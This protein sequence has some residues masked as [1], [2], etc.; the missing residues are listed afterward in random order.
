M[1]VFAAH[2]D[3]I[4]HT[5]QGVAMDLLAGF[6]HAGLCS[7]SFFVHGN[8]ASPGCNLIRQFIMSM[9]IWFAVIYFLRTQRMALV[10]GTEQLRYI[11][12]AHRWLVRQSEVSTLN[13]AY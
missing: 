1:K 9:K 2:V 12:E 11:F 3:V 13:S 10:Q 6:I 7:H 8:A 4:F 5:V